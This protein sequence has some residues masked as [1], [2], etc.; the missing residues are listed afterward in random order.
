RFDP[1]PGDE[2]HF[3]VRRFAFAPHA[4]GALARGCRKYGRCTSALC[5]PSW[6]R[7]KSI[8]N[9]HWHKF[10]RAARPVPLMFALTK[11]RSP[12]VPS[13]HPS[14]QEPPPPPTHFGAGRAAA[15]PVR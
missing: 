8:G 15:A 12:P 4:P 7:E 11:R 14:S 6:D 3:V 1:T 13:S 2:H 10:A 9:P 5:R